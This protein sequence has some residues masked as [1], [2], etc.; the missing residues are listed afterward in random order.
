MAKRDKIEPAGPQTPAA[1]RAAEERAETR[2][3]DIDQNK[4]DDPKD[5]R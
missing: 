1:K 2:R 3:Q 4:R 5:P